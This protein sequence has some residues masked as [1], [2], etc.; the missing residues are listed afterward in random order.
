[1]TDINKIKQDFRE[2]FTHPCS[3]LKGRR[4]FKSFCDTTEVE[5][6][7]TFSLEKA[8]QEAREDER[9]QIAKGVSILVKKYPALKTAIGSIL[10]FDTLSLKEKSSEE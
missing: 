6:F 3:E 5:S 9:K 1:M 7:L 4:D 8:I 10:Y 2:K